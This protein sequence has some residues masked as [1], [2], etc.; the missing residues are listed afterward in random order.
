MTL[1]HRHPFLRQPENPRGV[2]RNNPLGA[3]LANFVNFAAGVDEVTGRKLAPSSTAPA[4]VVSPA[5]VGL[6]GIEGVTTYTDLSIVGTTGTGFEVI[7]IGLIR[8]AANT[9]DQ[10]IIDSSISDNTGFLKTS[11]TTSSYTISPPRSVVS[12]Q[13][14]ISS[15]FIGVIEHHAIVLDYSGTWAAK[16]N[17]STLWYINGVLQTITVNANGDGSAAGFN[18]LRFL[19]I[20]AAS[21]GYSGKVIYWGRSLTRWSGDEVRTFAGNPWQV[22]RTLDRRIWAPAVAAATT[23]TLS[24]ATYVPGS[25]TSTGV[26][27]RVT[28]TAA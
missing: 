18:G 28:V 3:K 23:Y 2:D 14:T 24:A 21:R 10:R 25:I 17:V 20:Q 6:Q 9:L 27:A 7:L 16:A 5:G 12:G 1:L 15:P 13:F 22:L 8:D 19:G 11:A 4:K 26:Q